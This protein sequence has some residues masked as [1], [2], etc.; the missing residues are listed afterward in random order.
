MVRQVLNET[1]V[2][3]SENWFAVEKS[4]GKV[5]LVELHRPSMGWREDGVSE[6]EQMNGITV[7][8]AVWVNCRQYRSYDGHWSEWHQGAGATGGV[9]GLLLEAMGPLVGQW[10]AHLQKKNAQWTVSFGGLGS[11]YQRDRNLLL[12]MV[13]ETPH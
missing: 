13:Q 1:F 12:R 9:G 11:Q 10:S 5:H 4:S 8:A 2:G 3:D 6:T 7:K